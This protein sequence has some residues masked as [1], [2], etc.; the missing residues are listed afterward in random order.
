M[1]KKNNRF[2]LVMQFKALGHE[3]KSSKRY[4]RFTSYWF[5]YIYILVSYYIDP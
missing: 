3:Y 4:Y 2:Y 1:I 5:N